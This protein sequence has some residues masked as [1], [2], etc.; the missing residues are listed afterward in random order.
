MA[1]SEINLAF[2]QFAEPTVIE[3]SV[4]ASFTGPDHVNLI[5]AKSSI[6]EVFVLPAGGGN[7]STKGALQ[8]IGRYTL[9]GNIE[10]LQS[11]NARNRSES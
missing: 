4:R 7:G 6:L 5:V 8:R 3:H 1:R 9:F 11:V 10:S 2:Q